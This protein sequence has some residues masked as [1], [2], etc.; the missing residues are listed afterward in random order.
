MDLL[1][2][3]ELGEALLH[4]AGLPVHLNLRVGSRLFLVP[5]SAKFT[6]R[7]FS[8]KLVN[9]AGGKGSVSLLPSK[10]VQNRKF[11]ADAA[12]G[13]CILVPDAYVITSVLLIQSTLNFD[14][15]I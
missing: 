9:T 2:P 14:I 10:I 12:E 4:E 15:E 13:V 1:R 5:S 8:L 6:T 3:A 11:G 7:L